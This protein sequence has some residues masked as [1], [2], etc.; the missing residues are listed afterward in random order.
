MPEPRPEP[1]PRRAGPPHNPGLQKLIEG[2]RK[3]HRPERTLPQ[4][5]E[6]GIPREGMK[7]PAEI[8]VPVALGTPASAGS[9]SGTLPSGGSGSPFLGWHERGYLPHF[10]APFVTQFVAFMLHDA[11]SITR[12]REWE[13]KEGGQAGDW[14]PNCAHRT[15]GA[16]TYH[17]YE[18][19]DPFPGRLVN[20]GYPRSA[21][22]W[23]VRKNPIQWGLRAVLVCQP[24]GRVKVKLTG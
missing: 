5:P 13:A 20:R 11:F 18:S 14:N 17:R 24:V 15:R 21:E 10:D 3:W 4:S 6:A 9:T 2:K 22:D 16:E 8:G 23:R 1:Q 12:R 19:T 7:L